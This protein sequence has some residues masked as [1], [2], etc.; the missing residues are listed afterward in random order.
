MREHTSGRTARRHVVALVAVL[1][2]VALASCT[3]SD[4]AAP[5]NGGAVAATADLGR[6]VEL[7]AAGSAT[8]EGLQRT[9]TAI[10]QR[11]DALDVAG[12]AEVVGDTIRVHIAP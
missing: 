11:L 5:A 9:A 4:S 8:A 10:T 2:V 6:T 12:S 3:S 1:A 7:V